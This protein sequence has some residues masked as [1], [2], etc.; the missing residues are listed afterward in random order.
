MKKE[1]KKKEMNKAIKCFGSEVVM[2]NIK[3]FINQYPEIPFVSIGSGNGLFEKTIQDEFGIK[4][5]CIDPLPESYS[6]KPVVLYPE[7]KTTNE[8]IE[9]NPEIILNCIMLLNWCNPNE[10][11]YDY[12]AIKELKPIAFISIYE[13]YCG[14]NGAGGGEKFYNF[15]KDNKIYN[16]VHMTKGK[17]CGLKIGWYQK[18]ELKIP[19]IELEEEVDLEEEF[20]EKCIIM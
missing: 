12:D 6:P 5:I 20:D 9:K 11:T 13:T 1:I 7:Y 18:K 16:C 10:S 8:L 4:I 3:E 19:K 17:K 15:I 14:S 2:N